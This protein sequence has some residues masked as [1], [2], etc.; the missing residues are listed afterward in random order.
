MLKWPTS[1]HGRPSHLWGS[2]PSSL[3]SCFA[4][5]RE[6]QRHVDGVRSSLGVGQATEVRGWIYACWVFLQA[7]LGRRQVN[8]PHRSAWRALQKGTACKLTNGINCKRRA[9]LRSCSKLQVL[10]PELGS[11]MQARAQHVPS[12]CSRSFMS[13]MPKSLLSMAWLHDE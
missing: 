9:F 7:G 11:C 3:C 4:H 8:I 5:W 6:E 10:T 2:S 12:N 13:R 1:C